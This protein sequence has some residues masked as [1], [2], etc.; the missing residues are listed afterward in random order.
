MDGAA[1]ASARLRQKLEL[2][3]PFAGLPGRLLLEHPQGGQIYPRYLAAGY[4]V[5]CAMLELMEAALARAGELDDEISA[6]RVRYLERHI[7]EEMHHEEP[8]GAVLDDLRALGEDAEKLVAEAA[9]DKIASLVE[10]ERRRIRDEHPVAILGFLELEACHTRRDAVE[11]L[12]AVT[13]LPRARLPAAPHPLTPGR[14]P[15]GASCTTCSIR[16]RWSRTTSGSSAS[17]R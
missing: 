6:G 10:G 4:H 1:S 17:A 9:S 12:I 14:S 5:T 13:G 11:R 3:E 8:G 16:S 7:V 2:V 15:R